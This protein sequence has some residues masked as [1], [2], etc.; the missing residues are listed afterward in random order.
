[1]VSFLLFN[2]DSINQREQEQ[3][4]IVLVTQK[5]YYRIKYNFKIGKIDHMTRIKLKDILSLQKGY[6]KVFFILF[7][8]FFSIQQKKKSGKL[9]SS[10]NK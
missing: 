5:A 8:F 6:F 2:T 7:A 4:R 10:K 3:Q 9:I 1:L